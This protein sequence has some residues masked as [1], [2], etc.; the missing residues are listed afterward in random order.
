MRSKT[1]RSRRVRAAR[2]PPKPPKR[3]AGLLAGGTQ[4]MH[5]SHGL[6]EVLE[7]GE[8]TFTVPSRATKEAHVYFHVIAEHVTQ[9]ERDNVMK[10]DKT[11][12]IVHERSARVRAL[13]K[14][15]TRAPELSG[16]HA[17]SAELRLKSFSRHPAFHDDELAQFV[18]ATP[19]GFAAELKTASPDA[20]KQAE[21]AAKRII[22]DIESDAA[23]VRVMMRALVTHV[24][25][26]VDSARAT[27]APA[28]P[29]AVDEH[30]AVGSATTLEV[31]LCEN[32][33]R[34][35]EHLLALCGFAQGNEEEVWVPVL[36]NAT[37]RF[38]GAHAHPTGVNPL[39]RVWAFRASEVRAWQGNA[40]PTPP[41][42][43]N[44]TEAS[45]AAIYAAADDEIGTGAVDETGK[46]QPAWLLRRLIEQTWA[47]AR[48]P[49]VR[50]HAEIITNSVRVFVHN[51]TI[52]GAGHTP[53]TIGGTA[54]IECQWNGWV[55]RSS[56]GDEI[57]PLFRHHV[58][59]AIN[60]V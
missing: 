2:V 10:W 42:L 60:N 5:P 45:D 44:P 52:A 3:T 39:M 16:E 18:S 32:G 27:L 22:K 8:W 55:R 50:A 35:L 51:K 25:M 28:R 13:I 56:P 21:K 53:L 36:A 58:A 48:D 11:K 15:H 9:A 43:P 54:H 47:H 24:A 30:A 7:S 4:F 59:A 19:T 23:A 26:M 17:P 20:F 12:G 34:Y 37:E 33:T 38:M 14:A 1:A 41:Q 49:R 29:R 40:A 46:M 6:C 31:T 57:L